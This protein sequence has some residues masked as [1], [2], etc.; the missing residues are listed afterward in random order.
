MIAAVETIHGELSAIVGETA[1]AAHPEACRSFA[2]DGLE[3]KLVVYPSSAEEVAAVL[4]CA[5]DRGL[6]V[7]PVRNGTKLRIGNLPSRYDLALSLK[8]LNRVWHY[9]PADLTAVVEPGMKFGDLQHFLARD[10]LWLP[11]DP[12]GGDRASV[13]GILATNGTGPLRARFGAPRDMTLG[14]K[15]ATTEGKII[16]TGG[17]VVKN[18]AGYDVGKLVIGSWGTLGVIVEAC[19][20]LFTR[21]AGRA[22]FVFGVPT[23]EVARQLRRTIFASPLEPLRMALLDHAAA[24]ML[25]GEGHS[26]APTISTELEFWIEAGGSENVLSRYSREMSQLAQ[27]AGVSVERVDAAAA[28]WDRLADFAA[29][30][31]ENS[32]AAV[33]LKATLPLD[34]SEDFLRDAFGQI[35]VQAFVCQPGTGVV[36]LAL[37]EEAIGR[38]AVA[39]P[40]NAARVVAQLRDIAERL[41]GTL[42]VEGY[43]S[44]W[45]ALMDVW[46]RPVSGVEI[47]RKVKAVWDARG[48]LSA[49]RFLREI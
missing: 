45:K 14:M 29:H 40:E 47:M 16:K 1:V 49:G 43:P 26:Q 21:P 27:G 31:S 44:E 4:K 33:V 6:A 12:P 5:S 39:S 3:P 22:T 24:R 41:G 9:E 42:I 34:F 30:V 17:R 25:R 10:G 32:G 11:L 19:F 7:I 13:G 20:K 23:L 15:V 2:V 48:T 28:L 46:G 37:S 36:T 38:N 18:V 8:N 35:K